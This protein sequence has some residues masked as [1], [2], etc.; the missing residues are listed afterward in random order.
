MGANIRRGFNR[1]FVV[2]TFVWAVYCLLVYPIQQERQVDK[3][4]KGEFQNCFDH[5]LGKGQEFREC[6]NNAELK[7]TAGMAMWSLNAYWTRESWFLV[8]VVVAVPLL[9]YGIC[10]GAAAIGTWVWRRFRPN[11]AAG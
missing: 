5:L 6:I 9:V 2:L 3:V 8:L 1:L 4:F 11:S 7:A 10:R